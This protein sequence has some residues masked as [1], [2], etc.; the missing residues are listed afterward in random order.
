MGQG[1]L[2]SSP[3]ARRSPPS[4]STSIQC[5][6]WCPGPDCWTPEFGRTSTNS[7]RMWL[8]TRL[9][10]T[11]AT[12]RSSFWFTLGAASSICGPQQSVHRLLV[13]SE[14]A[15][16]SA[17]EGAEQMS[18]L[19]AFFYTVLFR[20]VRVLIAPAA[21]T[22][23]TWCKRVEE[24]DRLGPTRR[25]IVR[26]FRASAT[27]LAK[28]LHRDNYDGRRSPRHRRSPCW[29]ASCR[30][31]RRSARRWHPG[32]KSSTSSG[33]ARTN[34]WNWSESSCL[35]FTPVFLPAIFRLCTCRARA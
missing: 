5:S 34:A 20:T 14:T 8:P 24:S 23:L 18:T 26:Q 17:Y 22:T 29:S 4:A 30:S 19:A 11:Q 1:L 33:K 15:S 9:A 28:G 31:A 21:G 10:L 3:P 32:L 13:D 2:P 6:S 35:L 16:R 25:E 7:L 12:T 27:E